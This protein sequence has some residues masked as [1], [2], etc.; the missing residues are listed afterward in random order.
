VV[1]NGWTLYSYP[2]FDQQLR[3]LTDRVE[4]SAKSDPSGY[5]ELPATK[6]LATIRRHVFETIPANPNAPEFRQGNTLGKDNKHWFRAKFHERYRLF[7]RFSTRDRIIVYA[8][9]ND[10]SSLRKSGAKTDP[11]AMF[12]KMLEAG[13]PPASMERLLAAARE[14]SRE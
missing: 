9:V 5:K 8:W 4:A 11:Y 2:L 6:L 3:R 10:E 13:D 1:V 7:F 14:L 12:Q